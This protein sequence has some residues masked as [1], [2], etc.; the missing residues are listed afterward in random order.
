MSD[1]VVEQIVT[2]AN[3]NVQ[4]VEHIVSDNLDFVPDNTGAAIV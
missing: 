4:C 3:G 2:D 1:Q